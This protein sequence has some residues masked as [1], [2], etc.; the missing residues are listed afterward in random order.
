[1]LSYDVVNIQVYSTFKL[2]IRV[3]QTFHYWMSVKYVVEKLLIN[4]SG[5]EFLINQFNV[6]KLLINQ[7]VVLFV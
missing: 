2:L 3:T 4:Q 1:M 6:E 5:V 7:S